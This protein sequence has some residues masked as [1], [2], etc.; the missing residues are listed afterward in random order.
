G[1]VLFSLRLVIPSTGPRRRGSM[2]GPFLIDRDISG[3]PLL[4]A[5]RADDQASGRLRAPGAVA[6]R[7]LAPRRLGWHAGRR[8][9]LAAAVR[10]VAR[11]HDD[12]ADLGPLA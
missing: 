10:M 3:S 8:L 7:G 2:K 9:A 6:H 4:P 1:A 12:P 11:V 5:S